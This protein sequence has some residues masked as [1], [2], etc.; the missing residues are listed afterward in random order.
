MIQNS[1]PILAGQNLRNPDVIKALT[2]DGSN[3]ADWAKYS[4][5][6]FQSP[7]GPFQVH[8]YRNAATE[9]TN[10]TIDYK[11]VFGGS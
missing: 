11:V 1:R 6:T 5:Q 3:I 8:F 7:S 9:A 10:Y 2:A 4:T